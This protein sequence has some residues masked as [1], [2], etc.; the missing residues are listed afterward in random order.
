LIGCLRI[1]YGTQDYHMLHTLN[2][3]ELITIGAS[4]LQFTCL[5]TRAKHVSGLA[6]GWPSLPLSREW[7][8]YEEVIKPIAQIIAVEDQGWRIYSTSLHISA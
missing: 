4:K 8:H 5:A 7:N 1:E 3:I 2:E 6:Q